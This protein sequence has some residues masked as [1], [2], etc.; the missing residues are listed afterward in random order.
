MYIWLSA[1]LR[2]ALRFNSKQ[3][4]KTIKEIDYASGKYH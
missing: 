2:F 1:F 3:I 4:T